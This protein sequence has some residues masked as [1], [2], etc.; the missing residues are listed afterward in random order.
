MPPCRA[1]VLSGGG[2]RGAYEAGVLTSLVASESF[3]LVVGTSIGAINAAFVAQ[4]Q[5]DALASLWHSIGSLGIITPLPQVGRV[6]RFLDA[7]EAFGKLPPLAKVSHIA[8]LLLLWMQ[9]GSK[10]S[11]FGL[12][13]VLDRRPIDSLLR[14]YLNSNAIKTSLVVT[15]S[16]L[17]TYTPIAFYSFVGNAAGE[18]EAAFRANAHVENASITQIDYVGAVEASAAIPGAFEPVQLNL[19]STSTRL[20]VDGGVAN[21]TPIGLAI[22]AGATQITVVF[23]DAAT[24]TTDVRISNLVDVGFSSFAIMQ[25]KILET[26]FKL[27][28]MTNAAVAGTG[29]ASTSVAGKRSIPIRQIR[30]SAELA[31]GPLDFDRQTAI[32]QAYALGVTD[33]QSP[34]PFSP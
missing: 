15:A 33:G 13:G 34:P 20:F 21:N 26:D 7:F 31:V 27:A 11:L 18:R 1:L 10:A 6:E 19:G 23:V 9:I 16:D 3:D 25:Q 4:A 24:P 22:A 5:I 28:C 12:L 2:A 14:R 8:N 32:D 30:P 17:T 29:A